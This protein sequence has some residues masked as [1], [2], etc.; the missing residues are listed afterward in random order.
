MSYLLR[1]LAL[2]AVQFGVIP[3]RD[4]GMSQAISQ[5]ESERFAIGVF[6]PHKTS[7]TT[8]IAHRFSLTAHP[9]FS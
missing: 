6:F 8:H 7:H 4:F 3:S 1:R 2:T 9:R 5:P